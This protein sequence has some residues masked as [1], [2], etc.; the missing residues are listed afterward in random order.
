MKT[1]HRAAIIKILIVFILL[2]NVSPGLT[3][4]DMDIDWQAFM[5]RHDMVWKKLPVNWKQA[6]WFGNGLIGSMIYKDGGKNR[7]K[8]QVFRSDVQEHRPFT[9]GHSGYTRARLQIGSF[10]FEPKGQITGCDWRLDVYNAQLTGTITTTKGRINITHFTHTNDM[11]LYTELTTTGD[12]SCTWTWEPS[13][14]WP[15]RRGFADSKKNLSN[16]R[17]KYH[18]HYPTKV[19]DRNPDPVLKSHGDIQVCLQNLKHGGQHATAW[20][21]V[22]KGN[23]QIHLAS[24][25]K[26]WPKQVQT[27][28]TDAID[29][30]EEILTIADRRTWKQKHYNWWHDYY[31]LSFVS[32][33]DTR[34]ETDYW[35]QVYKLG[36]ASR[37]DYPVMDTPGLWAVPTKWPFITWNLNIQLC[38]WPSFPAN[39]I[40]TGESLINNLWKYRQNLIK[41]VHPE[42]WQDDSAVV[43]LNTGIDMEQWW[44]VDN[45]SSST[46]LGNLVWTLHN[47]WLHYRYTMDK[48]LLRHK[49]YPLLKRSVNWMIHHLEE[50]NGTL[51]LPPS[52]SPEYGMAPDCNYDLALLRWGCETLL[53]SADRLQIYDPLIPEWKNVL[54]NLIDFSMNENG[55]MIGAGV[56][57][58]KPHRHYSHLLMFYP[59]YLV[60]AEQPNTRDLL[61]KSVQHW[62]SYNENLFKKTGEWGDI[63]AYSFTGASSMYASLGDGEK[64]LEY[65]NGY[66]E[67]PDVFSNSLYGEPVRYSNGPT[68]ESPL[69]AAQC[70][71]DMLLQSWGDKI[72]IFPAVPAAWENVVFHNL[73]AQGAFLVS[74]ERS[75]G[76][77][78][79]ICIKSLAGEPCRIAPNISDGIKVKGSR[80]FY[81]KRV[82]QDVYEIDLKQGENVLIYQPGTRPDVKIQPVP[83]EPSQHNGYG[84]K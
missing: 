33:S 63:S 12:E 26:C 34:I 18:S 71:H 75:D 80:T 43:P 4:V 56:P 52:K 79:W 42:D 59:L 14:A 24:I 1:V 2:L 46:T 17:E 39:R 16:S 38:Y 55:F 72:R 30:I 49:L 81:V 66:I 73:R 10:Y 44:N 74:A 78:R 8:M 7:F 61:L 53:K 65:L 29:E 76:R 23:T 82:S 36:S 77:T 25:A 21:D 41:N 37:P 20:T 67:Y 5:S 6:P 62:M 19:F 70:V 3:R 9:Q 83:A 50:R 32:L 11:I 60:N 57:Y 31:S 15:T 58:D 64:A 35:T 54:E 48:E 22:R 27:A 51:H 47:V 84:L 28:D 45:R 69:S 40:S 68:L 13:N